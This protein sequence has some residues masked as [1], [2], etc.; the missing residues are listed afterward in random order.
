MVIL[1]GIA[2]LFSV[3][4]EGVIS[5]AEKTQF[6]EDMKLYKEELELYKGER[7]IQNQK[8]NKALND[9]IGDDFNVED[10]LIIK[11]NYIP[12][13]KNK[14]FGKLK[15]EKGKLVFISSG[16]SEED[17][18]AE[19]AGLEIEKINVNIEVEIQ[20]QGTVEGLPENGEA[21]RGETINLK[22]ISGEVQAGENTAKYEFAG[23]YEDGELVKD[24]EEYSFEVI[25]N[26]KLVAKFKT[27]ATIIYSLDENG[28]EKIDLNTNNTISGYRNDEKIRKVEVKDGVIISARAFEGCTNLETVIIGDDVTIHAGGISFSDANYKNSGTFSSCTSLTTVTMGERIKLPRYTYSANAYCYQYRFS[29]CPNLQTMTIGSISEIGQSVFASVTS[30]LKGTIK[31]NSDVT[32]IGESSFINC[33]GITNLILPN[34]ITTIGASAFSGCTNLSIENYPT[35]ITNYGNSCFYNCKNLINDIE[36]KAGT[37]LGSQAFNGSGIKNLVIGNGVE[38]SGRSFEGCE[39]LLT[40]TIG[41]DVTI[42]AG[43]ISF[44]DAN[45]KN[46]GTFSSCTSLTTVTMGE[47]I[48]LPIYTYSANENCYQYRFSNC[49]N[50]QTMTIGSIS[51]VGQS[52]FASVGPAL[53]G[54]IKI[55]STVTS[56]GASAFNG[57]SGLEIMNIDMTEEEFNTNVTKGK[58]WDNG[59]TAKRNYKE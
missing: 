23:W 36:I 42:H 28:N 20:G 16:N 34:S 13:M 41:D 37:K 26:R 21:L 32:T 39:N 30:A 24:T 52:V 5:R 27:N 55:N 31:I 14:Y 3:G 10:G 8:E 7:Q 35:G 57:C 46:A 51:E 38:I 4:E 29:N 47:R 6:L 58:N 54:T 59:V 25:G 49:P 1:A 50:L 48:K 33:T 40:L 12:S 43:G 11:E 45:Y 53:K 19:A 9:G 56:I 22:A 18:M 15:I 17:A 2:L 44:Y